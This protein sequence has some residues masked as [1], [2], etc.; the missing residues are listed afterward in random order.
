M[1]LPI[2]ANI[3]KIMHSNASWH[4]IY[5]GDS[6]MRRRKRCEARPDSER[7]S[8]LDGRIAEDVGNSGVEDVVGPEISGYWF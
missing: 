7:K 5:G 1:V 4:Q 6:T 8:P 3:Y 2:L